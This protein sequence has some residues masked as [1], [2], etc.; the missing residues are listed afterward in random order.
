MRRIIL[1]VFSNLLFLSSMVCFSSMAIAQSPWV[2]STVLEDQLQWER[3]GGSYRI[4]LLSQSGESP[5]VQEVE[6]ALQE[7]LG[8]GGSVVPIRL[9]QGEAEVVAERAR[10]LRERGRHLYFF[11]GPE[12]AQEFLLEELDE[13]L[14]V[15]R[16]WMMEAD[17]SNA[18]FEATLYLVRAQLD[19]GRNEDASMWMNRSVE[20]FPVHRPDEEAFPPT[21]IELWA[22]SRRRLT[23]EESVVGFKA[24]RDRRECTVFVNGGYATGVE[25]A[26]ASERSYL[27][28]YQ[29]TGY[30]Q[31]RYQWVRTSRGQARQLIPLDDQLT[32]EELEIE[33]RQAVSERNLDAIVY[34]GPGDC[35]EK[36]SQCIA[37]SRAGE[38]A[39]FRA[40][41]EVGRDDLAA[42]VGS[43]YR[44]FH[45]FHS[46][47]EPPS[48]GLPVALGVGGAAL[49]SGGIAWW[50]ITQRRERAFGCS[51]TT[52][53]NTASAYCMSI[54]HADFYDDSVRQ[55]YARSLARHRLA[56]GLT[57]A[58]GLSLS[59]GS[60][61]GFIDRRRQIQFHIG[62]QGIGLGVRY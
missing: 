34:V 26:V 16:Q 38:E 33:L 18:L 60:A 51:A 35:G 4:G 58:A 61:L 39:V 21:V 50:M 31:P 8:E 53:A 54:D 37:M 47:V 56:A 55:H 62:G 32:S 45:E 43:H 36:E 40:F 27:L 10:S 24:L 52:S 29:C 7:H 57:M 2:R 14:P 28:G 23:E 5:E 48:A 20:T 46:S 15:S 59:I 44:P 41:R 30:P 49:V 6:R 17:A 13:Y 22:E 9:A 12:A 1:V 3:Y 11:E 25:V 19:L 42:G